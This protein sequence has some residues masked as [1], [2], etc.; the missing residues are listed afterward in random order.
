MDKVT[1]MRSMG[2]PNRVFVTRQ[3]V[4]SFYGICDDAAARKLKSWGIE[5]VEGRYYF[6]NDV[7]QAICERTSYA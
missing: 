5:K 2:Y 7:A 4:A 6:V 3:D 1:V